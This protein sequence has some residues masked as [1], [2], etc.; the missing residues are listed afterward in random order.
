MGHNPTPGTP[1]GANSSNQITASE[2]EQPLFWSTH[3]Q[4]YVCA[5]HLDRVE[6]IISDENAH[7][8]F[9]EE[10]RF[11]QQAGFVKTIS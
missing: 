4:A 8:Q 3:Y 6:D 5:I 2:E 10:E 1:G 11:R 9:V 7:E